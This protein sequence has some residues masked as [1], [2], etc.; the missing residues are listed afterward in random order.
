M[1]VSL[2]QEGNAMKR[3]VAGLV[4]LGMVAVMLLS[5]TPALAYP[6]RGG[7]YHG[8]GGGY[9]VGGLAVGALTGVV[10]GSI[11]APRVYA[12][13]PVVYEPAPVYVQPAPVYVQPAPVYVVPAPVCSDYW[14]NDQWRGGVWV[15]GHFVRVCR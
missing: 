6:Y 5:P 12:A 15:Q 7:H 10:L 1:E 14:V 8:G 13:P 9:F 4:V 3:I 11:F 2:E